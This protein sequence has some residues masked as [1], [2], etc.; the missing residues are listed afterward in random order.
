MGCPI[1]NTL[2]THNSVG[3]TKP[4]LPR[5]WWNSAPSND[6]RELPPY[7][8]RYPGPWL[9]PLSFAARHTPVVPPGTVRTVGTSVTA[10]RGRATNSMSQFRWHHMRPRRTLLVRPYPACDQ[11]AT[12]QRPL[13]HQNPYLQRRRK[14]FRRFV[15]G[16]LFAFL[17][18]FRGGVT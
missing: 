18:R 1:V 7:P 12:I 5:Q 8:R 17:G 13:G 11:L 6:G 4:S 15:G 10:D 14:G 3:N 2:C 9:G 16:A